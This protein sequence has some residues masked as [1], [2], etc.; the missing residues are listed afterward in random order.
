[1]EI[2][3]IIILLTGAGVF[4]L[5]KTNRHKYEEIKYNLKNWFNE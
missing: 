1:M 3:L 4:F 2:L 5:R